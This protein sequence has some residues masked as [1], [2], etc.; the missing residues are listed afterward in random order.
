[1]SVSAFSKESTRIN[2]D[3]IFNPNRW[4]N[5]IRK[6]QKGHFYFVCL[7]ELIDTYYNYLTALKIVNLKAILGK[8]WESLLV[9]FVSI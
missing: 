4:E 3:A 7:H 8:H 6:Q 9:S 5:W 2:F 1:M